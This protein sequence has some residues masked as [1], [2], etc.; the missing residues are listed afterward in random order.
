MIQRSYL[1]PNPLLNPLLKSSIDPLLLPGA[2]TPRG[3]E[4]RAKE[5]KIL[6]EHWRLSGGPAPDRTPTGPSY[7]KT[8][9]AYYRLYIENFDSPANQRTAEKVFR[10]LKDD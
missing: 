4:K 1:N 2:T 5:E 6:A 3:K 8:L 9:R 7:G 10:N